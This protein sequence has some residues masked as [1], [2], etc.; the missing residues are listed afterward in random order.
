[1]NMSVNRRAMVMGFA[2]GCAVAMSAWSQSLQS[3][4][5]PAQQGAKTDCS[6]ASSAASMAKEIEQFRRELNALKKNLDEMNLR[7]GRETKTPTVF[8][9][10]ERRIEELQRDVDRLER[11]LNARMRKL[12]EQVERLERQSRSR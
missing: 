1:M 5:S 6:D 4:G 12:E 3:C 7:M 10:F 9:T 11:D 8:N 2:I